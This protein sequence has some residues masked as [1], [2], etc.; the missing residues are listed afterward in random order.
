MSFR[1]NRPYADNQLT[2]TGGLTD[3]NERERKLLKKSWAQ[4]FRDFIFPAINEERFAPLYSDNE[5]SCPNTPVNFVVGALILKEYLGQRENEMMYSIIFDIRFQYALH[6]THL[7]NQPINENTFRRFRKRLYDYEMQ[8]GHDLLKE[9]M[10]SLAEKMGSFMKLNHQMKRMDSLMISTHSKSMTRLEIIYQVNANAVKLLQTNH[11]DDLIPEEL[12][13]YLEKDDLND[14]IYYQ[15]SEELHPRLALAIAEMELLIQKMD[16]AA[17]GGFDEYQQLLRIKEEQSKS[18]EFGKIIPKENNEITS[19]SL[20]NPSDPDATFRRKSGKSH[21]GYVANII[22]TTGE[23]GDSLITDI[24]FEQNVHSDSDFCKEYLESRP[25]DAPHETM[26]SDG[27]Y[28]SDENFKLA[29]SKNVDLITTALTSKTPDPIYAD[30]EMNEDGTCVVKCP[31]GH[32]PAKQSYNEQNELCRA[33]MNSECCAN[34]PYR[35]KCNPKQ[36]KNGFVVYVSL[37]KIDR[38]K[39]VRRMSTEEYL[40]IARLRNAVEGIMSVLRR[41][42]RVD[43]IP[44]FGLVRTKMFFNVK[45]IAYNFGKFLR[46]RRRAL[47]SCA[48]AQITE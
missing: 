9:E 33:V 7:E 30:F 18:D 21:K 1:L 4:D 26:T 39:Y 2:L 27:A 25:D 8:T 37:K 24:S 40:K 13:H 32:T 45:V 22:E 42:F 28:A 19:Q 36:Q 11:R 41:K 43:E 10:I 23:D 44:V 34:C 38:A 6:T 5:A 29:V 3:L 31:C 47:V 15:R 14:V 12:K 17:W 16:A 46:S 35:D 48:L 20:Q